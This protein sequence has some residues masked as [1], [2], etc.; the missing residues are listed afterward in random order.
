MNAVLNGGAAP[1]PKHGSLVEALAAAARVDLAEAGLGYIELNEHE[2]WSTFGRLRDRAAHIARAL[3]ARGVRPHDRVA[4]IAPTSPAF[5]EAF[6]GVLLAGA[7]AVP[8]YPPVRLGRLDEYHQSTARM[9]TSVGARIVLTDSRVK[10]LLGRSIA[11]ARPTLG[12]VIIDDLLREPPR[13][14]MLPRVVD[15]DLAIIQ[16]SS[17]STVDPKPVALSHHNVL[18][19][20]AALEELFPTHGPDGQR[21]RGRTGVSWLPLYHDMGLIGSL[22]SAVYVPG[23][24]ALISPEHFLGKPALWLRAISRHRALVSPAPNFAYAY[25]E[26]R[27]TDEQLAGV[28]LSC[29]QLALNGA[30]PVVPAVMARFV[31]RFSRF[32]F[33]PRAMTP[34]YGL[35]E[36][37]LAVTF[38]RRA[39][40]TT[41]LDSAARP[42]VSVGEPIPG[43][44]IKICD[45]AGSIVDT[46]TLGR[47]HVRGPSVMTGYFGRPEDTARTIV[48]GWLDTGDL[49][50]V[51]DGQLF[52]CGRSKDVIIVRGENRAPHTF[53]E[54][55][56]E[57]P[58][59]RA[60][61]AV[62][63]GW[64]PP[65][66]DG[67]SLVMLVERA[68]DA[69]ADL[70]EAVRGAVV[71]RTGVRPELVRILA[72][73]TLPRTSSGKLRRREA[74]TRFAAG[75]LDAPSA[76]TPL[77]L[78][79]EV[80]RSTVALATARFGD[81]EL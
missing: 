46:R 77:R 64:V 79:V 68:N 61:C 34:V 75:K 25:C 18:S 42:I 62:A 48:D 44:S 40:R 4:L 29:W 63:I 51:D 28:D 41:T 69:P 73:G 36:A 13:S 66:G 59:V 22:L 45:D 57:L 17:G 43:V 2:T 19:Q 52:V 21:L 27:I 5:V 65:G 12:C 7:V 53:E 80:V 3:L 30:E 81:E 74:A 32:G 78:A 55:L 26:K 38:P 1:K 70:E 14:L 10:R 47:I 58:G 9:L 60:G 56:D 33:A 37:S 6:F 39:A 20:C 67:E 72:P 31:A 11:A 15:D 54:A 71:D 23:R 76:V 49:G 16:F 50:F 24:L 35:A 8:V